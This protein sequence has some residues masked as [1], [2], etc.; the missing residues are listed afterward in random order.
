MKRYPRCATR[1]RIRKIRNERRFQAPS[2]SCSRRLPNRK[3]ADA[4]AAQSKCELRPHGLDAMTN[5]T[6][7]SDA[8][9]GFGAEK[10]CP[11]P[12]MIT[13]PRARVCWA[14]PTVYPPK[15]DRM[16]GLLSTAW[17]SCLAKVKREQPGG[18]GGALRKLPFPTSN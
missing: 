9:V 10:G 2:P 15:R 4:T 18:R 13:K 14:Y 8:E 12:S 7:M 6:G 5:E 3:G 17:N 16:A 1:G 11:N